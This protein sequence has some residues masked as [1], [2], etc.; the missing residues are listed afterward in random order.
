[1]HS[2]PDKEHSYPEIIFAIQLSVDAADGHFV[3]PGL[4]SKMNV[5]YATWAE[6]GPFASC[7]VAGESDRPLHELSGGLSAIRTARLCAAF[8][9]HLR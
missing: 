8:S 6:R 5:Y 9:Y 4:L 1:M 2:N 7:T 3:A